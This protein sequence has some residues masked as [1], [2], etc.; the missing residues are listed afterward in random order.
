MQ[1]TSSARRSVLLMIAL[2]VAVA[3]SLVFSG[4]LASAPSPKHA[5]DPT[6]PQQTTLTSATSPT[7]RT[8]AVGA[9]L[10][11]S[12]NPFGCYSRS[13][14]P[15]V[16]NALGYPQ[17]VAYG[18]TL[19]SIQPPQ[20]SVQAWLYRWDCTLWIFCGWTSVGYAP[21]Y[22]YSYGQFRAVPAHTCSGTS[23]H[24]YMIQT[25]SQITDPA[26]TVYSAW[27]SNQQSA[28]CG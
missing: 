6:L 20:E 10:P 12:T 4:T 24:N 11:L 2:A 14:Y 5:P 17:A 8:P 23:N 21:G 13:D 19:C 27:T 28:N 16:S 18:W 25:Y 15:H 22:Y 9:A 3:I 7:G 1:R 26:G